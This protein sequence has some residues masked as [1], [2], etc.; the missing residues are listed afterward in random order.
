M[1][2]QVVV[3]R[4]ALLH[5]KYA[6]ADRNRVFA[7]SPVRRGVL[8]M[9]DYPG[10]RLSWHVRAASALHLIYFL[11]CVLLDAAISLTS[12]QMRCVGI[13]S[14]QAD[15]GEWFCPQHAAAR[16]SKGSTSATHYG[17]SNFD[18][19]AAAQRCSA[20]SHV[21]EPNFTNKKY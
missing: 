4:A 13:T 6:F 12:C 1:Q 19:A 11:W 9:C 2:A 21:I 10:C 20:F 17:T 3:T 8:L 7:L 16:E 5:G 14:S 18:D 15:D